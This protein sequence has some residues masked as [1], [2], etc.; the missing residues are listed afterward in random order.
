DRSLGR[1]EPAAIPPHAGRSAPGQLLRVAPLPSPLRPEPGSLNIR[2]RRRPAHPSDDLRLPVSSAL[3][4]LSLRT[5]RL[6]LRHHHLLRLQE[7]DEGYTGLRPE[8]VPARRRLAEEVDGSEPYPAARA[9]GHQDVLR[10]LDLRPRPRALLALLR[11]PASP[12][13]VSRRR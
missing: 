3:A 1:A 8:P 11:H 12:F 5:D 6:L 10:A 9:A 4:V 13:P 7:P 2:S